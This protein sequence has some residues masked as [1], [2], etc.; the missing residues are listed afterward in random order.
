M[1]LYKDKTLLKISGNRYGSG[2][3]AVFSRK[4]RRDIEL[5][6]GHVFRVNSVERG[7]LVVVH[8]DDIMPALASRINVAPNSA[9]VESIQCSNYSDSESPYQIPTCDQTIELLSQFSTVILPLN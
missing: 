6:E 7:F 2:C 5:N 9:Q 3:W 8:E 1:T 4:L